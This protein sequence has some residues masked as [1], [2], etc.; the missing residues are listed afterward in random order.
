MVTMEQILLQFITTNTKVFFCYANVNACC[1]DRIGISFITVVNFYWF[2][3]TYGIPKPW[4]FPF[5]MSYWKSGHVSQSPDWKLKR[6]F[7]IHKNK[8]Y[9][10]I[11][12]E[13]CN[14]IEEQSS[15]YINAA[16]YVQ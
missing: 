6:L 1:F 8:N 4:Y 5:S 16:I 14:D 12:D 11:D 13:N 15:E 2:T 7:G 9:T 3:G 10:L